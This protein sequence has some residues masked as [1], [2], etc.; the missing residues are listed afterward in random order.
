[1]SRIRIAVAAAGVGLVLLPA[2]PSSGATL[3][4]LVG[5]VGRNDAFTITLTKAGRRVTKL[6]AGRYIVV[7]RDLSTIH[8]FHLVGPGVNKATPVGA[9]VT[10]TWRLT[11]KKGTYRYRCDAPGHAATMKGSF[12]VT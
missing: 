12:R 6:K 8:N 9:K 10:R 3:P 1:M 5:T 2:T 4:K 11:L 7:V